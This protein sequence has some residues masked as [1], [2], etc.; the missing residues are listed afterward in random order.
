MRPQINEK[1]AER[2]Q[3]EAERRGFATDTEFVKHCIHKELEQ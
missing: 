1:L 2:V 3:E